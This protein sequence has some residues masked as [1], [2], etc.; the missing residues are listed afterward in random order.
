V[1][2]G[3]VSVDV[4]VPAWN[5]T[6]VIGD[7]VRSLLGSEGAGPLRVLVCDD[8]S[9]DDTGDAA[10]AAAGGDPRVE[11]LRHQHAGVNAAR[12]L[13]IAA[14]TADL[15]AI[16]DADEVV[17]PHYLAYASTLLQQDPSVSGVGGPY[18]AL[19]DESR[20]ARVCKR[21]RRGT[22]LGARGIEGGDIVTHLLGGNAVLRRA[23]FD[24]VGFFD[25]TLS[26][27]GDEIEWYLRAARSDPPHRFRYDDELAVLHRR[28]HVTWVEALR[29]GWRQGATLPSYRRMVG[30]P[31]PPIGSTIAR[32]SVHAVTWACSAAAE[33]TARAAADAAARRRARR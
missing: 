23:V 24:D 32:S 11:V 3:D 14:A 27:Y 8:G 2:A 20:G 18:H 6:G 4:V 26:G 15:V 7:C 28:D 33:R 9:T 22:G 29:R 21:C 10:R 30:E 19:D 12:N 31:D 16:V 5:A 13:G 17:P 1:R 25:P